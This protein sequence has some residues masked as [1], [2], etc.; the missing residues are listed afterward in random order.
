[1]LS[2]RQTY[3][4]KDRLMDTCKT[5]CPRSSDAGGIKST[6]TIPAILQAGTVEFHVPVAVQV[7]RFSP[8]RIYPVLQ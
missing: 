8:S 7:R 6:L 2:F 3:S 5:I 4:Q 1:M